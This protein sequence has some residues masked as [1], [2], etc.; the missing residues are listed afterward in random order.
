MEADTL[1]GVLADSAPPVPEKAERERFLFSVK[2][3]LAEELILTHKLETFVTLSDETG[4]R[5][6]TT[7]SIYESASPQ[8]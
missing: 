3:V 7:R 4:N 6:A 8:R 5:L 2:I 1:V